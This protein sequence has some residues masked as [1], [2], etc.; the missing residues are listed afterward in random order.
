MNSKI[1]RLLYTGV[2]VLLL[3]IAFV[4]FFDSYNMF[5]DYI[6]KHNTVLGEDKTVM[7]IEG[8]ACS[9][10]TGSEVI[11]QIL[12][13]K[14]R[15]ENDNPYN[16]YSGSIS[17][18]SPYSAE[19]L[20]SGTDAMDIDISQIHAESFYDVE[21]EKDCSGKIKRIQYTLR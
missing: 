15:E 17:S 14:E 11:H 21:I 12:Q 3:V 4:F 19:I 2:G 10:I 9:Q 6:K 16:L 20:I 7:L 18:S 5:Q 13:A 1:E 8:K